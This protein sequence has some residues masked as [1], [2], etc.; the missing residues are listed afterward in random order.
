MLPKSQASPWLRS[1]LRRT[2]TWWL[3][4]GLAGLGA[5]TFLL[6]CIR[7]FDSNNYYLI[8]PD[9]YFFHWVAGRV[10][11]GEGPPAGTSGV[12]FDLHSGFAYP[13]AYI[14]KAL[15]FTFHLSSADSLKLAC[16]FLPPAVAVISM[17]VL[18]FAV[19]RLCN[20]RVAFFC[21]LAWALLSYLIFVGAAGNNDRDSLTILLLMVG[22]ISFYSFR[23]W[24]FNIGNR[25]VRWVVAAISVL[26]VQGLLYLEW[27]FEGAPIMLFVIFVYFVFKYILDYLSLRRS[28]PSVKRRLVLAAKKLDLR[29]FV[30]VVVID[31]VIAG[32]NYH[33]LRT[34]FGILQG[35]LIG[36][37]KYDPYGSSEMMGLS[38]RD[39]FSYGFFTIPIVAGIYVALKW[40]NDAIVFFTSW[41]V[42]L[43]VLSVFAYRLLFASLPAAC[44]VSGAGLA[45]LWDVSQR[46]K[47]ETWKK[48][49]MVILLILL[50]L[51]SWLGATGIGGD[52]V[53]SPNRQWQRALAYLRDSTPEDAIVMSQWGCGYWILDVGQ[54]RP[55][56][57][58]GYYGWDVGRLHGVGLAYSTSNPDEAAA[59]MAKNGAEY[60][61]FAKQD[62]DLAKPIMAWAFF[63]NEHDEFPDESLVVRSLNGEF[64]GGDGLEVVFKNDEVVILALAQPVQK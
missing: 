20:R 53:L 41:F 55:L 44:V 10:I 28:E 21:A 61:V 13:L 33:E 39:L 43:V 30:L 64:V 49:G 57:D 35:M 42:S 25:D 31:L 36:R 19:A 40:R 34:S 60:L 50:F 59:I 38:L 2:S 11:S 9:S 27:G 22:A 29:P 4:L 12:N 46:V 47:V 16:E 14:A 18:Y 15:E 7:L 6:R 23:G 63:N 1:W 37:F 32:L 48:V 8:N 54:R 17:F 24:R 62:L 5:L 58:N 51:G 52:G 56:V 3:Y 45:Y 26:L